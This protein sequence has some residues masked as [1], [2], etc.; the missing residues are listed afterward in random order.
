MRIP[1][2]VLEGV[3]QWARRTAGDLAAAGCPRDRA[4][5]VLRSKVFAP[6][7]LAISQAAVVRNPVDVLRDDACIANTM[8]RMINDAV[9][10]VY[11]RDE[12]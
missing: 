9:N 3:R 12:P 6:R 11:G 5:K 2:S 1:E 7:D 10:E 4:A 8:S